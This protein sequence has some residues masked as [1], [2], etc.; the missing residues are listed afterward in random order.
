M[1]VWRLRLDECAPELL[2]AEGAEVAEA[3]VAAA[4]ALL[5]EAQARREAAERRAEA[6]ERRAEAKEDDLIADEETAGAPVKG[7]QAHQTTP[8]TTSSAAA[9]GN[10]PRDGDRGAEGGTNKALESLRRELSRLEADHADALVMLAC[11]EIEKNSLT[12]ALRK[13]GGVSPSKARTD[14]I[15]HMLSA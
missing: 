13:A 4:T 8:L 3:R 5:E 14:A 7:T 6:A 2:R 12:D 1:L 11:L 15:A 10:A 9:A